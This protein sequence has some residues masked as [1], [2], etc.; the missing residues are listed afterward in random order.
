MLK[1]HTKSKPLSLEQT[2]VDFILNHCD[3]DMDVWISTFIA[4]L[5]LMVKPTSE[6]EEMFYQEELMVL[7]EIQRCG[8]DSAEL[9][10]NRFTL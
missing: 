8:I 7:E 3:D 10:K 6:E 4:G 5:T 2:S 9:W 1:T